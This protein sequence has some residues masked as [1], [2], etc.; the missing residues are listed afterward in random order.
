MLDPRTTLAVNIAA[1]AIVYQFGGTPRAALR[2]ID[3]SRLNPVWFEAADF[4]IA[5]CK[6]P[7]IGL[8]PP[9]PD[10]TN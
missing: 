10:R 4:V 2:A 7:E 9:T 6:R 1:A 5:I 8:T 3:P